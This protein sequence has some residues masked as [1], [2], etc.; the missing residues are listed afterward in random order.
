M[1]KVE[2][3]TLHIDRMVAVNER[4]KATWSLKD[5]DGILHTKYYWDEHWYKVDDIFQRAYQEYLAERI[6][7]G[8]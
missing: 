2:Q 7:L 3:W 5:I 8:D 6:L 4:T 1:I